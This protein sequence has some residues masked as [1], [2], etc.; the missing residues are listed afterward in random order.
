MVLKQ[1]NYLFTIQ[2]IVSSISFLN[3]HAFEPNKN[4]TFGV[5]MASIVKALVLLIE[6]AIESV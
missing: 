6:F 5:G 4:D 3:I 2:F 1:G